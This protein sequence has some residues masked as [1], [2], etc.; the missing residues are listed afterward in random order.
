MAPVRVGVVR[1]GEGMVGGKRVG[2]GAL[3]REGELR[4]GGWAPV[5]CV[6]SGCR[7]VRRAHSFRKPCLAAGAE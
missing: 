4:G 3:E 7:S 5:G 1:W 2:V 6:S